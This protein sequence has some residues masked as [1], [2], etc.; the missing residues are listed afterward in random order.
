MLKGN[1]KG[2]T[3][4][5]L[6]VTIG[7]LSLLLSMVILKYDRQPHYLLADSKVLRDDLRKIKYLTMTEGDSNI[8]IVFDKYSYSIR[9]GSKIKEKIYLNPGFKL[10]NNFEDNTVSF[11]YSGS[12]SNGGGTV[13]VFDELSKKYCEITVVPGTGRILL[14]NTICEGYKGK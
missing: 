10:N 13:S 4:V 5:E 9:E 2:F 11:A 6:I 3:I 14:K 12:P 8:K 1:N 7:F